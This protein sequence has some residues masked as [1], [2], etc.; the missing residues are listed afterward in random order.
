MMTHIA[1]ITFLILTTIPC[2]AEP[3]Q[4]VPGVFG[5]TKWAREVRPELVLPDYPRPQMVRKEWMNLNGLW[6]YRVVSREL[7]APE[8]YQ[9]KILVPFPIE[10]PLSG[11]GQMLNAM[12]GQSYHDSCLWYRRFFVTPL[13]WKGQ[14]IWLHFGAVDWEA[15]VWVNGHMLGKHRGGYDGFSFDITDALKPGGNNE[16]VV[17]VWDPTS[18]ASYPCGKQ[19]C[20]PGGIF[21]TPCTGIWQT[22]W[23]EPV[24]KSASISDLRIVPDIDHS[25]LLLTAAVESARPEIRVRAT[26]MSAEKTLAEVIG[27]PGVALEIKL[28]APR[29]WT[30]DDPFLYDLKVEL[31]SVRNGA[32]DVID[33][34][35]SYFGMRKSS[36]G[37][38][39]KGITRMMLNNQFVVQNGLLDQG[40][41]PDGN[42]TAPTDE[43][44]R[45]D[46]EA[47]KRLGFNM[48]RKHIKV[49]SQRWYYWA[50]K[51]GLLVW[52]DMP[53]ITRGPSS[54]EDQAQFMH[55]YGRMVQ[56]RF[57]HPS[58][59]SWIL[60]NEGMGL[61]SFD[62]KAVTEQ[63]AKMDLTRLLNHESG[64]GGS[65]A[66]GSNKY[67]VGGGDLVDFHCYNKF[68][69]PVPEDRRASV[70]GEYGPGVKRFM[71]QLSKYAPFVVDPG[72]SGFVWTQT[73]DVE[74]EHNG[75]LTYD[76]SKFNEDAD[77]LRAQNL[78]CFGPAVR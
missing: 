12:P 10:A 34:V 77:K 78:K 31:V 33:T 36:L 18:E 13:A 72:V 71:S 19:T 30:P 58:I 61:E 3:Y 69:G 65:G 76:R 46:I 49:E 42:Y 48:A 5:M 57:N 74:N 53:C 2:M 40:Y 29:L 1:R 11:V 47:T 25:R 35:E 63:A 55:E 15:S 22:V 7:A 66:Q 4:A 27:M 62:L 32:F 41:W 24:A 20:K 73:T 59:V 44:L 54:K 8:V 9:G 50:D 39:G 17:G 37:K 43:A 68:V 52:Q 6:D 45:Y 51:L 16:V 23:L 70:I 26:V 21:Y 28:N 64:A 67:D 56:G 38:D 75:M 60:F 14:R